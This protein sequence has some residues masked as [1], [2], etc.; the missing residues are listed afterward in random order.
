MGCPA[1]PACQALRC[2]TASPAAGCA[3][4][5]APHAPFPA[6]TARREPPAPAPAPWSPP[7]PANPK[8]E[9]GP[10]YRAACLLRRCGSAARP[11][12]APSPLASALRSPASRPDRPA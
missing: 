1:Q 7:I 12:S 6:S 2:A 8:R 5:P 11:P 3:A 9:Q 10:R 4:R